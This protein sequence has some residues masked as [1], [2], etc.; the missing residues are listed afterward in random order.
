V[1]VITQL[2]LHGQRNYYA[3]R[4]PTKVECTVLVELPPC[5]NEC[6]I[7]VSAQNGRRPTSPEIN[8]SEFTHNRGTEDVKFVLDP[9][10]VIGSVTNHRST[11]REYGV[12]VLRHQIEF[13]RYDFSGKVENWH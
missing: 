6:F 8:S 7:A 12:N 5:A 3:G 1:L 10:S 13:M 9:L 11:A 2:V 4:L